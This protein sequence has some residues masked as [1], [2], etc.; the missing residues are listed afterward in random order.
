LFI[1]NIVLAIIRRLSFINLNR[2]NIIVYDYTF[3]YSSHSKDVF[4]YLKVKFTDRKVIFIS[5]KVTSFGLQRFSPLGIYYLLFSKNYAITVGMPNFINLKYKNVIQFQHGTAVKALGI[6]DKTV[7]NKDTIKRCEEFNAYKLVVAC[8]EY[9][10]KTIINSYCIVDESRVVLLITPYLI[11]FYASIKSTI[12]NSNINIVYIP[13]YRLTK[14]RKWDLGEDIQFLKTIEDNNFQLFTRYHPTDIKA[15]DNKYT[16]GDLVGKASI[17]ISDYSSILFDS[18]EIGVPVI[19]YTPDF[20]EYT[21]ERGISTGFE[22]ELSIPKFSNVT[23]LNHYLLDFKP[24]RN[25]Q[26]SNCYL[27][28]ELELYTSIKNVF[29]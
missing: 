9:S 20:Q 14:N 27:A 3:G 28:R 6:F 26:N 4:D 19:M 29:E 21:A 16:I 5:K 12:S 24:F 7:P 17:I 25:K 13:T 11:N 22:K 15:I 8:N 10:R 18:I 2:N 1:K 23:E